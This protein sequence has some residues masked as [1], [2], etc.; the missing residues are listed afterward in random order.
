MQRSVRNCVLNSTKAWRFSSQAYKTYNVRNS[1]HQY[2]PFDDSTIANFTKFYILSSEKTSEFP[3]IPSLDF[4][5]K[6]LLRF[7][8][9][10]S[11]DGSNQDIV[12]V[13][14]S[15]DLPVVRINVR[16]SPDAVP[17]NNIYFVEAYGRHS[18][19]ESSEKVK[20]WK[21]DLEKAMLRV[22][23]IGWKICLV[24]IW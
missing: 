5:T 9:P 23:T 7:L 19:K 14:R 18:D 21:V 24:G 16:P 17:F 1:Y 4:E 20:A 15:L 10:I 3:S 11:A 13:L 12:T 2:D 22:R 8:A 6:A